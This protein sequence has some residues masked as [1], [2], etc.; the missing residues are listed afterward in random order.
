[1]PTERRERLAVNVEEHER[2]GIRRQVIRDEV[3]ERERELYGGRQRQQHGD[4]GSLHFV[5]ATV[6]R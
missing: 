6:V 4:R 2:R 3:D 5:T 1:V